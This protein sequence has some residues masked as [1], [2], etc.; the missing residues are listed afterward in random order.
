MYTQQTVATKKW[1]LPL[2]IQIKFTLTANNGWLS[3]YSLE[4]DRGKESLLVKVP[5]I[6]E[7]WNTP[8]LAEGCMWAS[9]VS[10]AMVSKDDETITIVEFQPNSKFPHHTHTGGEEYLVL[11]GGG[12]V[13]CGIFIDI[14]L[15]AYCISCCCN[16]TYHYHIVPHSS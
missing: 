10:L 15:T 6:N 14:D 16:Y 9:G 4:R 12:N 8:E 1:Q 3:R 2:T 13:K 7:R 11:K 5:P